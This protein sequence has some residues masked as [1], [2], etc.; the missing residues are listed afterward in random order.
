MNPGQT[1]G[2]QEFDVVIA[3]GGIGG[4]V[5]ALALQR[6][7]P[8][9]RVLLLEGGSYPRDKVCGE[10]FSAEGWAVLRR[11]GLDAEL[12]ARG[13]R[14]V[15][16]ARFLMDQ[17]QTGA[18]PLPVPAWA[19]SRRQ[20]DELLWQ[21]AGNVCLA[22]DNNH[23]KRIAREGDGFRVDT[24]AESYSARFVIDAMGRAARHEVQNGQAGG[25]SP[26]AAKA[27]P[28]YIGTKA[29]FL[30]AKVPVGEVQLFPY[31][32]GYCG[33]I[34]VEAG[35]ANACLLTRYEA[36]DSPES[37][38]QRAL[39]ENKALRMALGEA[40]Q[41]MP[42]MATGNVSF[43]KMEPVRDGVLRCGDA[44]GYIQPF[45]GDGQAMA[46]RGAE[47]AAA[48]IGAA[49]RGDVHDND[50]TWMFGAAWHREFA[51]RL[52]WGTRLQP[53]LLTPRAGAVAAR[54][55]VMAPGAARL[56]VRLTRGG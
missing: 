27:G 18:I 42:W 46:A 32:G 33:V 38:W 31:R 35:R 48:S 51:T 2:S 55:M 43:G 10:F 34:Q 41:V 44:A 22:Y 6:H 13:A 49:L 56:L 25:E 39:G 9:A 47:L 53:L 30:H 11:L 36:F 20:L 37:L 52:N 19:I 5:A 1:S 14:P 54:L 4:C 8:G 21:H 24:R 16:L 28:R 50:A 23:V 29:H 45:A 7:A 26:Q 40:E 3:G 17:G 15:A 12:E